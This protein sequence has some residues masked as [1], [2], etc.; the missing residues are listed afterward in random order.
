MFYGQ[1]RPRWH[2]CSV[3]APSRANQPNP[4]PFKQDAGQLII[5]LITPPSVKWKIKHMAH[6]SVSQSHVQ[7]M[8]KMYSGE[9]SWIMIDIADT[10]TSVQKYWEVGGKSVTNQNSCVWYNFQNLSHLY[11]G[12]QCQCRNVGSFLGD[13]FVLHSATLARNVTPSQDQLIALRNYI[14][15]SIGDLVTE[16]L[17]FDFDITELPLRLVTFDQHLGCSLMEQS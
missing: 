12:C 5:S 9:R 17:T 2:G 13:K 15:S 4:K 10:D 16:S 3:L 8:R 11:I 7:L 6:F 1:E 14:F